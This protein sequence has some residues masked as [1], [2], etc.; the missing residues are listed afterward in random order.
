MS[1]DYQIFFMDGMTV[2]E[3]ITEN[4]DNSLPLHHYVR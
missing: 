1:F 3:V 2:N 4:E